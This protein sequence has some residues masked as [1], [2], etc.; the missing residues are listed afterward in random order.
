M[1]DKKERD[2]EARE[3]WNTGILEYWNSGILKIREKEN[4]TGCGFGHIGYSVQGVGDR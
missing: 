4:V 3:Y 1:R 2:N